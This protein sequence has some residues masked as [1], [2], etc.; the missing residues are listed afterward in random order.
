[1]E[2]SLEGPF[3]IHEL[4][5]ENEHETVKN[6]LLLQFSS[7]NDFGSKVLKESTE[8]SLAKIMNEKSGVFK[9]LNAEKTLKKRVTRTVKHLG[10]NETYRDIWTN[11]KKQKIIASSAITIIIVKTYLGL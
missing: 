7:T 6:Q 1:M 2:V 11:P 9:E 10:D 5:L 3:S 4:K 8:T